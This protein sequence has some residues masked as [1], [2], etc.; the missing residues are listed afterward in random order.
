[1]PGD[2][3]A[4]AGGG[5]EDL[6]LG[7]GGGAQSPEPR[8]PRSSMSVTP[9][10]IRVQRGRV[11]P[12]GSSFRDIGF[13]GANVPGHLTSLS[14]RPTSPAVPSPHQHRALA[15]YGMELECVRPSGLKWRKLG[16]ARPDRGRALVCRKLAAALTSKQ[17]FS[18]V[19]CCAFARAQSGRPP[20]G[21]C[22][23]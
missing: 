21:G 8:R 22:S 15:P 3:P 2:V 6:G 11:R 7:P 20:G 5:R 16:A 14:R 17:E 12:A 23:L 18:Q 1:M 19:L 13:F 4:R 9:G 10:R